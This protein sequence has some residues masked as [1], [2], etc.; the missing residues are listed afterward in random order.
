MNVRS[1]W[2]DVDHDEEESHRRMTFVRDQKNE[3][4]ADEHRCNKHP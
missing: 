2:A 3:P 4:L 1:P